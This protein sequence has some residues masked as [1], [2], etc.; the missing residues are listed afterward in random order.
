M[1]LGNP[2]AASLLRHRRL[3]P[4]EEVR[5]V[6]EA[7]TSMAVGFD[8]LYIMAGEATR[9]CSP[10]MLTEASRRLAAF[11]AASVETESFRMDITAS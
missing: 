11:P 8:L 10:T 1:R 5:Q 2:R 3:A 4:F 9:T 7:D 6:L